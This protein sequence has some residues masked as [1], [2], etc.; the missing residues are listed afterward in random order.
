M[1]LSRRGYWPLSILTVPFDFWSG[2]FC[3]DTRTRSPFLRER[4]FLCC[5]TIPP[6]SMLSH[7]IPLTPNTMT[8][9]AWERERQLSRAASKLKGPCII[10]RRNGEAEALADRLVAKKTFD[11]ATDSLN[12]YQRPLSRN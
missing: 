4:I 12:T 6:F 9:G 10:V 8:G 3:T 1:F 11:A 2:P 7:E 5:R